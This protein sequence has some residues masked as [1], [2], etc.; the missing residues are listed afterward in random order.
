MP[1]RA[2]CEACKVFNERELSMIYHMATVISW[3]PPPGYDPLLREFKCTHCGTLFYKRM[4]PEELL[5][6]GAHG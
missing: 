2:K 6:E 3:R 1:Y 4:T 5:D